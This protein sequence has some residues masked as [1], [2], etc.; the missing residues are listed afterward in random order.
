MVT[1]YTFIPNH[2][3]NKDD[4]P[5]GMTNV[6]CALHSCICFNTLHTIKGGGTIQQ[7]S[8]DQSYAKASTPVE[9]GFQ[10]FE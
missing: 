8:P 9:P 6:P 7:F 4:N 1:F 10:Y 2:R 5:L 3:P